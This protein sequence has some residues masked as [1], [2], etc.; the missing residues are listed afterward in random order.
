[1]AELLTYAQTMTSLTGGRGDYS[2]HFLRY[3]EVPSHVAQKVIERHAQGTRGGRDGTD[4]FHRP[5]TLAGKSPAGPALCASPRSSVTRVCAICERTLLMGEHALRFAPDG[6]EFVDVCPLCNDVALEY[7][8]VREG[9]PIAPPFPRRRAAA[10]AQPR[11]AARDGRAPRRRAPVGRRA[12][13]AATLR[14]GARDR[15]GRRPLQLQ[16]VPAHDRGRRPLARRPAGL[17]RAD[18]RGQRRESCSRSPGRSA[19]TSTASRRTRHQPVRLAERGQR[20]GRARRA[21][22]EWNAR[23]SDDGRLIPDIAAV[24]GAGA[25]R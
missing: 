16:P 8:W 24:G 19:G 5:W 18:L 22:T 20:P 7:G 23:Q 2:M 10:R 17:D 9:C 25:D 4:A 11:V 21:F 12:D 15:R 13:P 6:R 1:M 14:A 3:E